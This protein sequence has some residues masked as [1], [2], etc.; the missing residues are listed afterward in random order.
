MSDSARAQALLPYGS[1]ETKGPG[2]WGVLTLIATEACLF[3]YLLFGY[4]FTAI[5]LGHSFLPAKP[6]S[7]HLA[8]PNTVILLAS[9]V[10][11]W[12][13]E[14]GIKRGARG[15][16]M[17]GV[18][19]A[20]VL[21]ILFVAIQLRE[22]SSHKGGVAAS[23]YN[24]HYFTITGFHMAHVVGGL[25]A[26]TLVL[27]WTALGYFDNRRHLA[28]RAATVYWHFVDAVWLCVFSAFYLA[29]YLGAGQ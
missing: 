5:Q 2:W 18:V 1:V 15:Q 17:L 13:G 28:V 19:V 24:S 22:W 29:P 23:G 21:G 3:A 10:A 7:I 6:P 9:S 12:W 8:G 26:L 16:L 14:R 11:A 25:I 4:A 27:L 20:I